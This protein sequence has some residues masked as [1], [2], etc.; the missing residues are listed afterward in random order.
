MVMNIYDIL[1]DK[2]TECSLEYFGLNDISTNYDVKCILQNKDFINDYYM[3]KFTGKIETFDEY[4]D[5]L[6]LRKINM[7]EELI[8]YLKSKE[9]KKNILEILEHLKFIKINKGSVIRY[10]NDYINDIM[11]E[12]MKYSSI[13]EATMELITKYCNGISD[14][15][16]MY[17]AKN[18]YNLLFN[19]YDKLQKA[20]ESKVN[21]LSILL[22]DINIK[23][24]L[25]SHDFKEVLEIIKSLKERKYDK[26]KTIIDDSVYVIIE[27]GEEI[28]K[29]VTIET[30]LHYRDIMT[31][32]FNFLAELKHKKAIEFEEYCV[33]INKIEEK[34]VRLY[35]KEFKYEIPVHQIIEMLKSDKQW[36]LKILYLTHIFDKKSKKINSRLD[37][38]EVR[39]PHFLDIV[40][41]N[42]KTN[43]F[44]SRSHQRYLDCEI[45]VGTAVV[46]A[47]FNDKDLIE[48]YH[49][50]YD[51][52]LK[53]ICK[54]LDYKEL[55]LYNDFELLYQMI[56]NLFYCQESIGEEIESALSYGPC[57]YICS[58]TEKLLRVI[59]KKEKQKEEYINMIVK[60]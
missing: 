6:V 54:K 26:Y 55:D 20:I 34:Y 45:S 33:K 23:N 49:E 5:Y 28:I 2:G 25:Y 22:S 32:I 1:K 27:L 42:M 37:I 46:M 3:E 59:Y 31:Q 44:F 36:E 40:S 52:I 21:V 17:L 9:D 4:I 41:S 10:I 15:V 51:A 53:Y 35:G 38:D 47:I 24:V 56:N 7:M 60:C 12:N 48:E 39:K 43:D 13:V 8:D 11:K 18:H 58:L 29:N 19:N 14:D 57:M 30:S 16:F 50:W